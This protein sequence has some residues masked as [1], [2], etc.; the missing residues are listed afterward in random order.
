MVRMGGEGGMLAQERE[1]RRKTET[2]E[3]IERIFRVIVAG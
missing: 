2:R 3:R 1:G